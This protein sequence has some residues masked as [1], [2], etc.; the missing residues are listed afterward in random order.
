MGRYNQILFE[1][2]AGDPDPLYWVTEDGTE[3]AADRAEG[4]MQ[5]VAL[6]PEGWEP[7]LRSKRPVRCA[8]RSWRSVLPR[9][10]HRLLRS[11]LTRRSGLLRTRLVSGHR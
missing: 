11:T 5:A 2:E 7:L 9:M 10:A 1:I 6:D 4:F 3:I 8:C